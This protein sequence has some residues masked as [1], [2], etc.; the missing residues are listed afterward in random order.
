VFT[1]NVAEL[2]P[3][4]GIVLKL[5]KK[6][7]GSVADIPE[8]G[9][10]GRVTRDGRPLERG[11]VALCLVPGATNAPNAYVL[12]GRTTEGESIVYDEV[13]VHDGQYAL[14]VPFQSKKWY[15]KVEEP[16][17]TPTIVGPLQVNLNERK[18]QDIACTEGGALSGRIKAVPAGLDNQLWVVAF[19]KSGYRAE[20]RVLADRTFHFPTLPPGEYGL[21]VGH[22][23]YD[24]SET[25]VHLPLY[26]NRELTKEE[27]EA[28]NKAWNAP[29]DPWKR[30]T[31]VRVDARREKR[32]VELELP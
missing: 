25:Q 12:R 27:N 22:D 24:D 14:K 8:Q 6:K 2:K 5:R 7:K 3:I 18:S 23:A 26:P 17:Q 16:G 32:G 30:A 29:A 1:P 31:V 9:L 10:Y 21:K 11:W 28:F 13:L 19:T 4:E 15:L 20:T